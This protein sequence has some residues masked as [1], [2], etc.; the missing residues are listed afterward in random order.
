VVEGYSSLLRMTYGKPLHK[1]AVSACEGATSLLKPGDLVWGLLMTSKEL[2]AVDK[3]E[4][5]SLVLRQ[6]EPQGMAFKRIAF[7][8]LFVE[9]VRGKPA[10]RWYDGVQRRIIIK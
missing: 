2:R 7:I 4:E 8:A 3:I 9:N 1:I 6:V 5:I 10:K